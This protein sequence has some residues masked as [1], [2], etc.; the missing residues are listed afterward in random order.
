MSTEI[1]YNGQCPVCSAEIAQYRRA[2]DAAGADL[3]FVDLNSTPLSEWGL[4]A[5]Q[6]ARR[7]HARADGTIVSGLPAFMVVWQALPRWRWLARLVKLP[8]LRHVAGWL[9]DRIAAPLLYKR[10]LAR[11]KRRS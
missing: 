7:L 6:A 3:C 11:Q 5:D 4:D 8:G 2:A 9:Y 10:H 1:L